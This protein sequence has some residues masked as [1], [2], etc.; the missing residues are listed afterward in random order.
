MTTV[1]NKFVSDVEKEL[2]SVNDPTA[3]PHILNAWVM[4]WNI[5]D[6]TKLQVVKHIVVLNNKGETIMESDDETVVDDNVENDLHRS[7]EGTGQ[8]TQPKKNTSSSSSSS[9]SQKKG[10]MSRLNENDNRLLDLPMKKRRRIVTSSTDE[11]DNSEG[12]IDEDPMEENQNE[13]IDDVGDAVEPNQNEEIDDVGDA[14]EPNEVE[15]NDASEDEANS[16]DSHSGSDNDKEDSSVKKSSKKSPKRTSGK[17]PRRYLPPNSMMR[18]AV[19][20]VDKEKISRKNSKLRRQSKM[21]EP[22][23]YDPSTELTQKTSNALTNPKKGIDKP[24]HFRQLSNELKD[25]PKDVGRSNG[26]FP[27]RFAKLNRNNCS[28]CNCTFNSGTKL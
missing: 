14:V 8:K 2:K 24:K 18:E 19:K 5:P 16:D 25:M 15:N 7:K 10:S 22:D 21:N 6:R 26:V 11:S 27:F 13:E 9:R 12:D 28:A 3:Y 17:T 1:H 4:K 20:T 23:R